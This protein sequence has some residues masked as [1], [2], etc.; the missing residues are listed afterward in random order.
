M[1]T[2]RVPRVT[3]G[4]PVYNG[5]PFLAQAI[6]SVLAQT[7]SD[8]EFLI[9]DNAST[10][11]TEE[12]CRCYVARDSRVHY[13]RSERNK[14]SAWNHNRLVEL[15]DSEYFHWIGADDMFAPDLLGDG[16]AK[17]DANGNAVA[18]CPR[19]VYIGAE[20]ERVDRLQDVLSLDSEDPVAR[21]AS[22]L[23]PFA[24]S[25]HPFYALFRRSALHR[26]RLMGPYLA[27][28]R[29]LVAE[30][31][32]LG[33]YVLSEARLYNRRHEGNSRRTLEAEIVLYRP[34]DRDEVAFREWRVC[35]ENLVSIGKASLGLDLKLRLLG[36]V[37]NWMIRERHAFGGELRAAVGRVVRR[38]VPGLGST[39]SV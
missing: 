12:I 9:S 24:P 34:G 22:V 3:V 15:S 11:A 4:L 20:G 14:G 32:L 5:E 21:F 17:L 38:R 29:C 18:C 25:Y 1:T 10:D 30:L 27:A 26:T 33:P 23:R 8:F 31:C 7:F 16:V 19:T 37:L 2:D 35:R 39:T 6:E 36:A 13:R 28:D